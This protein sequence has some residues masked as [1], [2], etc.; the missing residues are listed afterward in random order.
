MNIIFLV[1]W[2]VVHIWSVPCPCNPAFST[3][4]YGIERVNPC[5]TQLVACF[6]HKEVKMERYFETKES[7][8]V[9][10]EKG[11]KLAEWTMYGDSLKDF[12]IT[13]VKEKE[14]GR[15]ETKR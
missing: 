2:T 13:K 7:A 5:L 9:F 14:G 6:D 12:K 4:E 15:H 1:T 3:D 11:E 8:L 10:I